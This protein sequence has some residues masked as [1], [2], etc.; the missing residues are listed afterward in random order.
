VDRKLA[1]STEQPITSAVSRTTGVVLLGG[2]H[3]ALA[4]AR[5]FGRK[6]IPVVVVTDDYLLPRFSRYVGQTFDWPGALSPQASEWL[7]KFAVEHDLQNWLLLA[8]T[9]TEV[10]FVAEHLGPLRTVFRILGS[11][12]ADLQK[13]CDKQLLAET[14]TAAGVAVPRNYRV[15]SADDAARLDVQ[16]PV[17][18]KPAMRME[19]NAFTSSKAWRA[20]SRK[21]LQDLYAQAALLVGG[22]EVVVQELIPGG[23]ETQFSYAA[24]WQANAPIAEM[25]ARRTR[26]YPIEFSHTST[27]VE[28]VDNDEVKKAGRKLLSSIGFE[29][30][31]EVEFK[32]DARDGSYKVLDVNP[33]VWSWFALCEAVGQDLSILMRDAV[34]GQP[35]QAAEANAGFA[36]LH[37]S[38][39]MV[40]GLQLLVRGDIT[41][42]AYV[43]SLSRKLVFAA[44]A[45]D[46]P[47]PGI[48]EVPLVA[49]RGFRGRFMSEK[50]AAR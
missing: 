42:G 32:F 39:D 33:R 9:D 41:I 1:L 26:Q 14:A 38:K 18:L 30:L 37:L 16:F 27:F 5:S 10:K 12:W 50:K 49:F 48:L 6:N 17:V 36:W 43:R 34:L 22:E 19:R 7:V 44:F 20:N 21:E 45:W 2:A 4:A 31:V 3:G 25:S 11:G 24:L 47:L 8:C 35:V 28:V 13:V 15:R 29:G 23:G 40:V 46:D